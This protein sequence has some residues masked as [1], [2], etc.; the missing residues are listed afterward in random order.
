MIK[1]YKVTINDMVYQ[2]SV[3]SMRGGAEDSEPKALP[4]APGTRP[5]RRAEGQTASIQTAA[6]DSRS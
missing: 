2:V 5:A 3:E 6:G 1:R 4:P